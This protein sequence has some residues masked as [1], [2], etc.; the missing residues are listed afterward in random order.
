MRRKIIVA[1]TLSAALLVAGVLPASA[2]D[3]PRR[4]PGLWEIT[5]VGAGSGTSTART[6]IAADDEI[7]TPSDSGDC[8]EPKVSS[9]GTDTTIVDVVCKSGPVTE[10]ISGAFT[11][12][13]DT[14]YRAQVKISFDPPPRGMPPHWG[15]TVD[16]IYLGPDCTGAALPDDAN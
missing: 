6:C 4:K 11:G 13:F 5:T 12:D 15:L 2:T 3:S 8:S 10:T 16:G 14:R 9:G 7:L 1:A